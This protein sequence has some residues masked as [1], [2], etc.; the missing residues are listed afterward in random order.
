MP[1]DLGEKNA[2]KS[3]LTDNF[4]DRAERLGAVQLLKSGPLILEPRMRLFT[5][6][7]PDTEE[8]DIY[9]WMAGDVRAAPFN[10]WIAK[11]LLLSKRRMDDRQL[12]PFGN[13]LPE[14][15][16]LYAHRTYAVIRFDSKVVSLQASTYDY[17]GGAHEALDE[18]SLNWDMTRSK[19]I[20][21]GDIFSE[22]KDWKRFVVD[23][24]MKDLRNQ[25]MDGEP[26]PDRSAVAD[27]VRDGSNWLFA[28]NSAT[29]HFTV[30]TVASFV[31]GEFGVEIPY[32]VL[33]PHMKANALLF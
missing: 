32:K 18:T 33:R 11:T 28:T 19:P 7:N 13:D 15:M 9:P 1:D 24:C 17:T 16:K 4:D 6:K 8:G 12:F 30:Y 31:G 14:D 5:R 22:G 23:Y 21:L 10:I 3:C 29:V 27:V 20:A 26:N 25:A 2:I